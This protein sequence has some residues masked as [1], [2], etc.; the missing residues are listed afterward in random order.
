LI[1]N[2]TSTFDSSTTAPIASTASSSARGVSAANAG[3][4]EEAGGMGDG[5]AGEAKR[6]IIAMRRRRG[7][8]GM[9]ADRGCSL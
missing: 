7:Q 3:D 8:R 2:C 1:G 4:G 5:A 9:P 6:R